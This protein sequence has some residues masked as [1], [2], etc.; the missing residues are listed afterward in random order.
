[1]Q[2]IRQITRLALVASLGAAASC[3]S[4]DDD[5]PV[6]P[7]PTGDLFDGYDT[8]ADLD[9]DMDDGT[10]DLPLLLPL[11]AFSPVNPGLSITSF[12][13]TPALPAG[14]TL[15]DMTG[16]IAGTPTA[17]VATAT[18]TVT[19]T[20]D[21][22]IN[23]VV[24]DNFAIDLG[25]RLPVVNLSTTQPLVRA[26]TV[27]GVAAGI[28][29]TTGGAPGNTPPATGVIVPTTTNAPVTAIAELVDLE[30][31]P[32]G[33]SQLP[34][35]IFD[36]TQDFQAFVA[37]I[38][39]E[40]S[41]DAWEFDAQAPY[42]VEQTAGD[43]TPA[44]PSFQ[45]DSAI[46]DVITGD[47]GLDVSLAAPQVVSAFSSGALPTIRYDVIQVSSP[48]LG[49]APTGP[50]VEAGGVFHGVVDDF[51]ETK[52]YGY[53]PIANT[54]D[55]AIDINATGNDDPKLLAV[56]S[57]V[58]YL[59][60]INT[61]GEADLASYDPATGTTLLL[62]DTNAA[63][64]DAPADVT[65]YDGDVY[66]TA[67][68]GTGRF[69][70]R[71]DTA[72][73]AI[74]QIS[75]T[76]GASADDAPA[77]L[78]VAAG[79]LWFTAVNNAGARSVYRF[80]AATGEQERL[81]PSS[82][83]NPQDLTLLDG[84]LYLTAENNNGVRKLF[85]WDETDSRIEQVTD[86]QDDATLEDGIENLFVFSDDLF[87]SALR[88]VTFAQKLHRYQP[89][90]VPLRA[91]QLTNTAGTANSDIL[92]EIV[93]VGTEVVFTAENSDGAVQLW[94]FDDANGEV[95]QLIEIDADTTISSNPR[96]LTPF[97]AGKLAVTLDLGGGVDKLFVYDNANHFMVQAADTAG[98]GN[99]DDAEPRAVV[100]GDTLLFTA[101][102]GGG[103]VRLYSVQ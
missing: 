91:E 22:G 102:D 11:T 53:D 69:V 101:N 8:D 63:G 2:R 68:D 35:G 100:D 56:I 19:A 46:V 59:S 41:G 88:P 95:R 7:P 23:P 29:D 48:L 96:F 79:F 76:S 81:T 62:S 74:D 70:F 86:F 47:L 20:A 36:A 87:F 103:G 99:T 90:A 92:G 40:L 6:V 39:T 24:T 83:D 26:I 17:N 72:T 28:D 38:D 50:W 67:G 52:L 97:G 21:D 49:G 89:T 13:V 61:D 10:L 30:N 1:M 43:L 60:V 4:N 44:L 34:P 27:A 55:E 58:A 12:A 82:N 25:V 37:I 73:D 14:L 93:T 84:I 64:D 51:G 66:F 16:D 94:S 98:T 5:T 9:V 77:E 31:I 18:Y 78:T 3:S 85:R 57:D 80:D 71:F 45:F 15:D 75:A 32:G 33:S 65:D 54:V 42:D